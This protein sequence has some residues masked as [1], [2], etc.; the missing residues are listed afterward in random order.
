MAKSSKSA[1]TDRQKV[2]E[3]MRAQQKAAERRRGT[4]IVAACVLVAVGIVAAAATG[5]ILG[6]L[7]HREVQQQAAERHRR[8]GLGLPAGHHQARRRQP[9]APRRRLTGE[10]PR[11]A[12]GLRQALHHAGRHGPEVLHRSGPARARHARAQRGARLHDPLVRR[13]RR[14]QDSTKM[15]QIK[16]IAN[17]FAGTSDLRDKFKAVPWTSSDG[18]P[19]PNGQHIAFTHWSVG[20]TEKAATG[21]CEAGRRVAV[22]LQRLRRR[23][24]DLHGRLPVQRLPRAERGLVRSGPRDRVSRS[25]STIALTSCARARGGDQQRVGGV[26]DD[27]VVDARPPRPAVRRPAPRGPM[28]P[29]RVPA[30]ASPRTCTSPVSPPSTSASESK[31]PMSSQAN[32]PGTVAT[33]PASAAGSATAWSMAIFGRVG[34]TSSSRSGDAARSR[35][36]RGE[37]R[38]QDAEQVEQ[39]PRAHDEHAGVPAVGARCDVA[40]GHLGGRLLHELLDHVRAVVAGQGR[41]QADVAE[42]RGRAGRPDADRDQPVVAGDLRRERA[43]PRSKRSR[44]PITWSAANERHHGVR[45]LDARA[46]PRRARSPPSSRAARARRPRGPARDLRQ[47]RDHRGRGGRRRSPRAPGPRP[48]AATR[49]DRLLE[50]RAP[51]AGQ[52]VQELRATPTVTT[53]RG[54]CPRRR[55]GRRPR[56]ARSRTWRSP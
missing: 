11:L 7:P 23:A 2:V 35:Q 54:G 1:S 22:L 20:G 38:V 44:S 43:R 6:P 27:H 46:A 16:A 12:A 39:H 26:D 55:P 37:V 18:S 48:A 8:A 36:R 32:A 3:Q 56:S 9:A 40:P 21:R 49:C 10:L 14:R 4:I 29:R 30:S 42:G 47:L 33:R 5:P 15:A 45:I 52:V 13:L 51:A 17:K 19:F 53:A 24:P 41:A 50:Q 31:S 28:L 34:Q 25:R